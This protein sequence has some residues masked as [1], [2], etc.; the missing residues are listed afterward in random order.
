[1]PDEPQH[2][3]PTLAQILDGAL[4]PH[5]GENLAAYYAEVERHDAEARELIDRARH[6][7]Q[8]QL[9]AAL[10]RLTFF[11]EDRAT[12]LG[13][14]HANTQAQREAL[15]KELHAALAEARERFNR[16]VNALRVAP[17][18]DTE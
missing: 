7:T 1:M 8:E 13:E 6:V 12:C 17:E 15:D 18:D 11:G 2:I 16:R 9:D 4:R 3:G 14:A 5:F 10:D